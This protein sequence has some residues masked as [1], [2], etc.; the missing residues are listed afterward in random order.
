MLLGTHVTSVDP[1]AHSVTT[2]GARRS[3]MASCLGDRRQAAHAA[4]ARAAT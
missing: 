4:D 3:A 1:V 2:D